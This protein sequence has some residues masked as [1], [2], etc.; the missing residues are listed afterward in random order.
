M[1]V[2]HQ[3]FEYE[4]KRWLPG[5]AAPGSRRPELIRRETEAYLSDQDLLAQF[6]EAECEPGEEELVGALFER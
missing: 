1:I 4:R 2:S 3:Q 6:I 5:V